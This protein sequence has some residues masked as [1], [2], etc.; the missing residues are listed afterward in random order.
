[1]SPDIPIPSTHT[2]IIQHGGGELKVTHGIPVPKVL[3]GWL[4]VK[5]AAVALNPC[6]FK[7]AARFPTP[8]LKNGVDFA[9]T[10]AAV[11]DGVT[12][13]EVGD[14]V[15]GCVPSNKQDDPESGSFGQYIKVEVIYALRI[16]PDTSFEQ[17]LA[18]GPACVST[19]ALALHECLKIPATPDEI[20]DYKG[21]KP[22]ETVLVY[23]GS[24]SVGLIAIQLLKLCGYSVVTTCS[25]HNFDLVKK[26]GAD[27]VFDYHSPTCA[28][29]IKA[30]T[31]NRLK[32]VI[33]P[34]GE[35]ATTSLCYEAIGR[36]GGT[37]CALEQYQESLCTRQTVHHQLVMGPAILGRGVLLPEPYG[38]APDPELHEWSKRFYRSL[39]TLIQDGTLKPLPIRVL[40]PAGFDTVLSGLE[41][42]KAKQVSG[43][44]LVVPVAAQ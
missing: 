16:P 7:M 22:G 6:D 13:F 40:E 29:D 4:L 8:G 17:A 11:G 1:M 27:A 32:R 35:A 15:F 39:Q 9:G 33:D 42:L 19:V 30:Y 28:A 44:K 18:F 38:I 2:A 23:G 24:S 21:H 20:A 5:N 12:E 37:Y 10:V 31:R 43:S 26:Y 41:I 34:F 36:A 3:P 25:P 14:R